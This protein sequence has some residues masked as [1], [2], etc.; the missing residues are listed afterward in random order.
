MDLELI[1]KRR[2]GGR[3]VI[4]SRTSPAGAAD[5]SPVRPLRSPRLCR[6]PSSLRDSAA[7]RALGAVC[8]A[9]REEREREARGETKGEAES[10]E[11]D[12]ARLAETVHS[13]TLRLTEAFKIQPEE[14]EEK[15]PFWVISSP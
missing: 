13:A 15:S 12:N 2:R 9:R 14:G 4:T 6:E 3:F 1:R 8:G 5:P 7:P 11:T 10:R